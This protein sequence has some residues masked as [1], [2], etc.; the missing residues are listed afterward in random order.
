MND[1]TTVDKRVDNLEKQVG[2][3][4]RALAIETKDRKS[5]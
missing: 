1:R 3:L 4:T 5:A 2:E